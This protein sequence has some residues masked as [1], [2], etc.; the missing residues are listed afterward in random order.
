VRKCSCTAS[1]EIALLTD[2]LGIHQQPKSILKALERYQALDI[3]KAWDHVGVH[4]LQPEKIMSHCH[5]N[6]EKL[7]RRKLL[8]TNMQKF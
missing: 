8:P 4:P 7:K 2:N 3:K 1:K 6:L 5:K